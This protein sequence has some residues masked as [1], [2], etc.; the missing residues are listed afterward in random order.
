MTRLEE[1]KKIVAAEIGNEAAESAMISH[2]EIANSCNYRCSVE[3]VAEIVI[4]MFYDEDTTDADEQFE[5]M[6]NAMLY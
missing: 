5:N 3:I 1:V 4:D 2:Y 6:R